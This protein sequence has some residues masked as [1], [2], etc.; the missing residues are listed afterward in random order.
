[1]QPLKL[2]AVLA[3]PDDESLGFGRVL[4]RLIQELVAMV[5]YRQVADTKRARRHAEDVRSMADHR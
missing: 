5:E 3:H 1:M 2:T 4:A